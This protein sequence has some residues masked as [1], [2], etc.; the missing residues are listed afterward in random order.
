MNKPTLASKKLPHICLQFNNLVYQTVKTDYIV[1]SRYS[2]NETISGL[3]S[4]EFGDISF[5]YWCLMVILKCN[6][7]WLLVENFTGFGL[8]KTKLFQFYPLTLSNLFWS[9]FLDKT[10]GNCCFSR[11]DGRLP[12]QKKEIQWDSLQEIHC[13]ATLSDTPVR[14]TAC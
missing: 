5:C 2:K 13:L 14:Y 1:F 10:H 11:N 7:L 6:N 3:E 9:V 4:K 12:N 8:I